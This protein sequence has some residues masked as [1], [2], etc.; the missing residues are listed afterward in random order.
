MMRR[1]LHLC[2]FLAV[3]WL[4]VSAESTRSLSALVKGP[5]DYQI[6]DGIHP[7]ATLTATFNDSIQ[8]T[9]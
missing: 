3:L 4:K 7:D 2:F 9:G 8:E 5:D 1:V 6:V